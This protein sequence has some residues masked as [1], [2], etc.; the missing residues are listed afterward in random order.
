MAI[1]KDSL[2]QKIDDITV[3]ED[4][5]DATFD[6]PADVEPEAGNPYEGM[7]GEAG[8]VA[9]E[10][11]EPIQVAGLKDVIVGVAKGV[12]KQRMIEAERKVV[13]PIGAEPVQRI[14][15]AMVVREASAEE[16]AD[17]ASAIGGQ[18]TKGLNVV[19][20][21][22]NL[23]GYDVSAHLEKVK[24]ANAALFERQRRGTI[25]MQQLEE[26]A[27]EQGMDN[28]VAEWLGRAPGTGETAETI[29]AGMIAARQVTNETIEA[30][31]IAQRMPAGSEREAAMSK[32]F[33]LMTVEANLYANLSGAVSEAGR[34]LYMASRLSDGVLGRRAGELNSLFGAGNAD[35]VEHL[36]MLYMAIPT[37]AGKAKFVQQG[38]LSKTMDVVTEVWINSILTHPA[39]H[40]VNIAGN[41]IFQLTQIVETALAAGIG[42]LRKTASGGQNIE[43]VRMREALIRLDAIRESYRD[44][45]L[46]AGRT[47]V[48]EEASDIAS[49]IDVRNRRAIGS[50]G[51]LRVVVD[52]LRNG[53]VGAGFVNMLGIGARLGG[54][55][56]LAEDEF[57]KGIAYRSE[58]R[59][60]AS[61]RGADMY[62]D[63]IAAGKSVDEAKAAAVAEEVRIL[64]NPPAG[65]VVD[66]QDAAR[67][68][69]FQGDLT[70]FLGS[71]QGLASHPVM[72]LLMP[73]YK[74]P[75]NVMGETVNRTPLALLNPDIAKSI[76]AGGRE[77][78]FAM[79]RI[80]TGSALMSIFA[81]QAAGIDDPDENT[82][83]MGSGPADRTARQAMLRKGIQPYSINIKQEDG[84]Y[85]SFTFSRL[86][87]VSGL[88]AMAAD[89]A[90][91]AKHEDDQATL[92]ALA[93]AAVVGISSYMQEM[94]MLDTVKDLSRVLNSPDAA[95]RADALFELFG[96]KGTEATLSFL[97]GQS[98]FSAGIA[99]V[100]DPTLRSTMM[101]E[102]GLFGG[103]P[104]TAPAF[105]RGFYVALQRAKARNPLFNSDLP[106][107]LNLWGETMKAGTG[108][109][110]EM[111]SPIRIQD[112]KYSP[113]D[114]ELMRLGQGLSMPPKKMGGVLLN[115]VQY[116]KL[117][118]YM[119]EI[120]GNGNMPG[121]PGY[122][123]GT[124]MIDQLLTLMDSPGYNDDELDDEDRVM[125]LRAVVSGKLTQA[126]Q[127]LRD[128]DLVLNEKILDAQ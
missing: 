97:P 81:Y 58:L 10:E 100:N 48:T 45:L 103:D 126:K 30:L 125:Q 28:I 84:S 75:V 120:D 113:I 34:T 12:S 40:A 69:T 14:G 5:H 85:R 46:V 54:R 37:R 1:P 90:Y 27:A 114:D 23:D 11:P 106:P 16:V 105:V 124:T 25:N 63:A 74:T 65:L 123:Y 55:A 21:G 115:A 18:Y 98:A 66:A 60:L 62:D 42:A 59:V 107:R 102:E 77:A 118:T 44:A 36:G 86:D 109:G 88:L 2:E 35:D 87:P 41:S 51:D 7:V 128:E 83:I 47:M 94:P 71:M 104:T 31:N 13:P 72:K 96:Q 112:T 15:D 38:I 80:A 39:T 9:T 26:M 110:W 52:E 56:L 67:T 89:F 121:Q 6:A 53:N 17:L 3:K 91:Y 61:L 73:F 127:A 92:D 29:L 4:V 82:I 116:N 78:D 33:Q 32:F 19:R 20:I 76:M 57:F 8:T 101:P 108:A 64:N 99:R 49:K 95:G 119:N 122:Q 43:R 111:F 50:T 93:T 117:I 70:G 24:D 22:D 68:M 79:A